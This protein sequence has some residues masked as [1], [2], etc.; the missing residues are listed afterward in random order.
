MLAQV[1][2][3]L[4]ISSIAFSEKDNKTGMPGLTLGT[5]LHRTGLFNLIT[6]TDSH[7]IVKIVIFLPKTAAGATVRV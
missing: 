2:F 4:S 3:S 7:Q 1:D 5:L 6:V